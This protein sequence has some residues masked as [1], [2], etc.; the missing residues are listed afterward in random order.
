MS[1]DALANRLMLKLS[2][3]KLRV[4]ILAYISFCSCTCISTFQGNI[5]GMD[6][7]CLSVTDD[8]KTFMSL[9]TTTT[10]EVGTLVIV[11]PSWNDSIDHMNLLSFVFE[12]V[13]TGT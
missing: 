7:F 8:I 13:Q 10:L 2:Y 1:C 5:C 11:S 4:L 9:C 12:T 6:V 3:I